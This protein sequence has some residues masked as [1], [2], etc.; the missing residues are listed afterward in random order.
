MTIGRS[1]SR[2]VEE[3]KSM[4]DSSTRSVLFACVALASAVEAGCLVDGDRA[5]D[6][7][8]A[9]VSYKVNALEF[10]NAAGTSRTYSDNAKVSF[11][12][13]KIRSQDFFSDL[14]TNGRACVH[15][16]LPGEGWTITPADVQRRFTHPL[17]LTNSDC[18]V[19]ATTCAAVADPINAGLDPIFRLNDGANSPLAD[20]STA[21]AR[22]A[23][24][25]MLLSRGVIRVGIGI[26][27]N[28]EFEL[29]A[30]DDPYGYA[31]AAELSLFRRPLPAT[32]L[33]LSPDVKKGVPQPVLTTVMWDG[34]ETLPGH[35]IIADL[36]D[37]AN[38]AT[39]GH[40]QAA[41]GLTDAQRT[42]I[43]G[44]ET[45]MH[46]AQ[47]ADTAAGVLNSVHGEGGPDWLSGNQ[48]F[49]PGINDVLR[50]DSQ[51]GAPF[52]PDV[53][54]IFAA[55]DGSKDAAKAQIARG[56]A[57]FNRKPIAIT[58]VGG[59]NDAL[60]LPVINGTCTTCHDSPNYGHHSVP[61][62]INIGIADGVRR[63]PDLPLYTLRNKTTLE[64]V[65]TT[66]PG[67]ALIT[68][69]WAD[70]GKFKG[71]ILRGLAARAPYFHNGMAATVSDVIEFYDTR[72]SIGF[73]SDEKADLA[74]FLLAL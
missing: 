45:G 27:A 14:G 22:R 72:F 26:P 2:E 5:S 42:S 55:W 33:R 46:T 73:T 56:E 65:Q 8:E 70:I 49:Y 37:Q 60:K 23:A 31:S 19:D 13:N 24:Y 50:G 29:I 38:G 44:F 36:M 74:A 17:D 25:S 57:L 68:G 67:R 71:P 53:F 63:T 9:A 51:T 34:R 21:D 48:P 3:E 32:N 66:D 28:A 20:V 47:S 69:R 59:L 54:T 61:L 30:V 41:A 6:Q 11:Q 1:T 15:C 58:G 7:Y 12:Q 39:L 10:S 64:V 43:V 16:H 4:V 35:D 40:A 52:D 18:V 62:P